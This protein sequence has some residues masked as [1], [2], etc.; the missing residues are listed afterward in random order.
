MTSGFVSDFGHLVIRN[1]LDFGIWILGFQCLLGSST[2]L[3][4][5]TL[6]V[7]DEIEGSCG[8]HYGRSKRHW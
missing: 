1:Y 7:T 2:G 6:G 5:E 8:D 4:E 3:P